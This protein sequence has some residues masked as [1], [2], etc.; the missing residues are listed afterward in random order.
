MRRAAALTLAIVSLTASLA[1]CESH[2]TTDTIATTWTWRRIDPGPTA[3]REGVALGGD[4]RWLVAWGGI[5]STGPT[6]VVLGDGQIL[7][8]RTGRW[9]AMAH[10]PLEP[11][12]HAVATWDDGGLTISAGSSEPNV[13]GASDLTD[14]ATYRP[15]TDTWSD[16]APMATPSPSR[17]S[18]AARRDRLVATV[19]GSAGS[20]QILSSRVR[21][22]STPAGDSLGEIAEH[23]DGEQIAVLTSA[24]D[25]IRTF[26][27]WS[28]RW[29]DGPLLPRPLV[30]APIGG[31]VA[32]TVVDGE[33]IVFTAAQD[34][35]TEGSGWHR[36]TR[37]P[38]TPEI[39]RRQSPIEV[40][41]G[42]FVV[43]EPDPSDGASG[44]HQLWLL[45]GGA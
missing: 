25:R 9:T 28:R 4:A 8:R 12:H 40:G 10:G 13:N 15:A 24:A 20:R 1:G 2:D 7:D 19:P 6:P 32:L 42:L 11:R 43:S 38:G 36:I 14:S 33:L 22:I 45:S 27:S 37:P 31:T 35:A 3:A 17:V 5:D 29:S 16:A 23:R 26:D 18:I 39:W 21:Q 30:N 41:D 44:R 34:L